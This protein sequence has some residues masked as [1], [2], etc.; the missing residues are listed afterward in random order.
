MAASNNMIRKYGA[1]DPVFSQP[2]LAQ[3]PMAV[4]G[5]VMKFFQIVISV[6]IGISAGCIPI[7]GYNTGA[8]RPERNKELLGR[9]IT[10]EALVGL[11]AFILVEL[12]PAQLIGIFGAKNESVYYT[13]FAIHAF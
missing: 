10:A 1:V 5:I 6:V 11:A 9:L 13:A 2:E 7:V 12:C 3:I 4:V 8:G